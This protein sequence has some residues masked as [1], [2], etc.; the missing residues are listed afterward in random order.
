MQAKVGPP[1]T[2]RTPLGGSMRLTQPCATSAMIKFSSFG[3]MAGISAF[4][5]IEPGE[6]ITISC[7]PPPSRPVT[8]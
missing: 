2:E 4:R 7:K 1:E 8:Q 3:P 6:E 5:D